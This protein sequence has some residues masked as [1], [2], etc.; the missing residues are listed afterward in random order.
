[1]EV[2]RDEA[3]IVLKFVLDV[4]EIHGGVSASVSF[5]RL[6]EVC[7]SNGELFL[8]MYPNVAIYSWGGEERVRV[9]KCQW[10]MDLRSMAAQDG[11]K[12]SGTRRRGRDT[13]KFAVRP[14]AAGLWGLETPIRIIR[15]FIT[16]S[17]ILLAPSHPPQHTGL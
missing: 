12:G 16:C 14:S 7:E 4:E 11:R 15:L 5:V 9:R 10:L 3:R 17:G 13:H 1:M 8:D 6:Q 2:Y